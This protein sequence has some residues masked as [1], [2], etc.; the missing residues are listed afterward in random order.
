M[1]FYR[2]SFI[3]HSDLHSS[4]FSFSF[5]SWTTRF[6]I[7]YGFHK[8]GLTDLLWKIFATI[9]CSSISLIS[10]IK[11]NSESFFLKSNS[12]SLLII[13]IFHK[14]SDF[15]FNKHFLTNSNFFW[16]CFGKSKFFKIFPYFSIFSLMIFVCFSSVYV[17]AKFSNLFFFPR[18]HICRIT[19]IS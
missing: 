14:N 15:I 17:K 9:K 6:I 5:S 7:I 16:F 1:K 11:S 8:F 12:S 13:L 2:T 10:P 3:P 19:I 4:H 18:I